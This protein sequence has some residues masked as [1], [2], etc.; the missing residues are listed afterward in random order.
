MPPARRSPT[1]SPSWPWITAAEIKRK[2][3]T[4]NPRKT[5]RTGK[6]VYIP[7]RPALA[8][9]LQ[10]RRNMVAGNLAFPELAAA[11]E[12]D[13]G[14]VSKRVQSVFTKAGLITTEHRPG[15]ERAGV[16][17]G[18]HSLRHYFATQALAAGIP[19]EIVKRITGH[20]SDAMLE[21]YEHVDAAMI[22]RFAAK[23]SNG[24]IPAALPAHGTDIRKQVR[25]LAKTLNGKTL[26]KVKKELKWRNEFRVPE[27]GTGAG[28]SRCG[29]YQYRQSVSTLT[30]RN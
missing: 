15:V 5:A 29:C 2:V 25:A 17:Y 24:K 26:G 11:Y 9:L 27:W 4:L 28:A 20:S 23:L 21:G 13:S 10:K 3:I 12:R 19:G 14:S 16:V 22:S 1:T 18:A 6:T 7:L 8:E 30:I